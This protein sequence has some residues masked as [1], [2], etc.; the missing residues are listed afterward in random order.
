[1]AGGVVVVLVAAYVLFLSGGHSSKTL[2]IAR[3]DFVSEVNVS[4]TVAA[5]TDV[6]LGFAANGRILGVY[7]GVGDHVAAGAILAEV[8]NADLV[9]NVAEER[10][11]LDSLLAGT[12]P[13][14][15]A[16]Y[17]ADVMNARTALAAAEK[18]AYAYADD[19]VHNRADVI[20]SNPRVDP[21]LKISV[22]NA[23]LQR[24]L[25]AE[26]L[27]LEP[28]LAAWRA[29]S[30][31]VSAASAE[32]A[33]EDM[34][35]YLTKVTTFL[36]DANEALNEAVPD[37]NTSAATI[38]SDATSLATGR[39]NIN[40]AQT[41]FVA[42]VSTLVSAEKTLD[43]A[44][45][46]STPEDIAAQRAVVASAQA[47]LAKTRVIAPISGIITRM[48]AK[49]GEIVSPSTSDISMQSDGVFQIEVYIP[50]V[51][52]A[53]VDRGDPATTTLD[54]YGSGVQFPASVVA[55]DPAETVKDGVPTYKTTLIFARADPRIRSGMTA[56]VVI[57]TGV[58]H[59]AIVIPEGAIGHDAEGAYVTL[60]KRG[61][62]ERRAVTAGAAPSLGQVEIMSGLA[63]GETIS[64]TP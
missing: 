20:F 56:N 6:N 22:P 54:A 35:S 24:Q 36:S 43:L 38:A 42:D 21:S 10:A 53:G 9:A 29:A 39:A 63:G 61:G 1:M 48:D 50:E 15:V 11:K 23:A 47:A 41:T 62:R 13:E 64:L 31:S 58:L 57:A 51:S 18:S 55:V 59:N 3:S 60:V 17:E 4:G 49:R 5:A 7:A 32:S 19:A 33:T 30:A 46:G 16:A 40:S 27:A 8:E 44:K 28:V 37:Q 12:R 45:A 2:T 52:I 26:R 25:E 14:Q 34:Q